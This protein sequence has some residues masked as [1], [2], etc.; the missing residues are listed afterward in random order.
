MRYGRA[1]M[2]DEPAD[3]LTSS[4]ATIEFDHVSKR[5]PPAGRGGTA[6]GAVEDL[7]LTVPAGRICVLVGP[8]GCGKTT[9]LKMVNRLIEPSS[10]RIL[11]DGRDVAR[12]EVTELRRS[13]GYVIQQTGL[14]PHQT[15]AQNVATVPRLLGWSA[16]RQR[17][18]TDELLGL[19]GLEPARYRERYPSQLSGGERQR[20]G[21]ARALAAD[22]PVMLMDEPV[23]A[24]DPIV[25]ERL[26]NEF[27][28]LQEGLAKT[29]LFVTHDIDEAIKMGDLVVVMQQGGRIAQAGA[30]ADLL[31]EPSSEYVARFVGADRGLKRLSLFRVADVQ[32]AEAPLARIGEP[33]EEVRL[34]AR[35]HAER[36]VL[37]VDAADRPVG[38]VDVGHLT[39]EGR[40]SA[41]D[42]DAMS[43]ELDRRTTLKDALSLLLD[44][45]VRS[46][47]VVDRH[48]RVV[49]LLSVESVMAFL[50]DDRSREVPA[51]IAEAV[52]EVLAHPGGAH[53]HGPEDAVAP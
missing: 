39:R 21:V 51:D 42:A 46:G 8:S 24:V 20:V 52:A 22:P 27:L 9:T 43:P 18:R 13:I 5:Y 3:Q 33:G 31:A 30:P 1:L 47:I 23:G 25:R 26:Q 4:G 41:T 6:H 49:G 10:G 14:F 11:V 16:D 29:I 45:G 36:Y 7:T 44:Q 12:Q 38:W 53:E 28:R 40:V 32:L 37:V 19:V 48:R 15:I 17:V 35:E 2:R 34:R 50:R